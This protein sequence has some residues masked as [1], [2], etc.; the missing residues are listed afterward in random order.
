MGNNAHSKYKEAV[1]IKRLKKYTFPEYC[2]EEIVYNHSLIKT[3][4]NFG[5]WAR[6]GGTCRYIMTREDLI[7]VD[8]YYY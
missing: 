7:D 2:L 5:E 1:I 4:N 8:L 3:P 6:S